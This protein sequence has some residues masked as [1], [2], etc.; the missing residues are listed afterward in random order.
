MK[1]V[2]M[3]LATLILFVACLFLFSV[4]AFAFDDEYITSW[5]NWYKDGDLINVNNDTLSGQL[6]YVLD[7]NDAC[8]YFYFMY[9]NCDGDYKDKDVSLDFDISNS[10]NKYSFSVSKSGVKNADDDIYVAYDFEN[11]NSEFGNGRL[12]VGFEMKNKT[13]RALLNKITCTFNAGSKISCIILD[14]CNFDMYVEPK[15]VSQKNTTTKL[16]TERSSAN[17]TAKGASKTAKSS[18]VKRTSTKFVPKYT[19]NNHNKSD[20]Q[21]KNNNSTKFSGTATTGDDRTSNSVSE[22]VGG[23]S[24]NETFMSAVSSEN[25]SNMSYP[26]SSKFAFKVAV[27]FGILGIVALC[28]GVLLKGN[29]PSAES[30][31]NADDNE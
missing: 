16:T 30:D 14:D 12:L 18:T 3:I 8:A 26:K 25:N 19:M 7:E 10:S 28:F 20:I 24:S 2:V 11:V 13:D 29:K 22:S 23:T 21:N 6:R 1:R 17:S 31:D 9:S 15:T 4:N 27:F 5:S